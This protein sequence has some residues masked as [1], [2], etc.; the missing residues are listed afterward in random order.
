MDNCFFSDLQ[1]GYLR[2]FLTFKCN[3]KC[4]FCNQHTLDFPDAT[5][6]FLFEETRPLY[7]RIHDLLPTGGEITIYRDALEYIEFITGNYP[8]ITIHP[9]SNG[10]LWDK[11]WQEA[12][13]ENL[14]ETHF[15]LNAASEKTYINGVWNKG[16]EA[17]N[18]TKVNVQNFVDLLGDKGMKAFNPSF[19][20][21][22]NGDTACDVYDF[23][24]RCLKLKAGHFFYYLDSTETK[25][26]TTRENLTVVSDAMKKALITVNE[27]RRVLKGKV[28]ISADLYTPKM[29]LSGMM[30]KINTTPIESLNKKYEEL[31]ELAKGRNII[32]EHDERNRIRKLKNKR[33]QPLESFVLRKMPVG[34]KLVCATPW[35]ALTINT[36][37]DVSTCCWVVN[38]KVLKLPHRM[39]GWEDWKKF[40]N[41]EQFIEARKSVYNGDY[42]FCLETCPLNKRTDDE[43]KQ[44]AIK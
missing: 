35:K 17:F 38:W 43:E 29:G 13:S 23:A 5:R 34:E 11:N 10:I 44:A 6:D 30:Q 31:I 14:W 40:L 27:I 18:K 36:C 41:T 4:R 39:N 37:R 21:V 25:I 8:H 3:A 7:E 9:E 2:V 42:S 32:K 28:E 33:E 1:G 19:S 12:A 22:V 26:W 24:K 16:G 20:M 15:S